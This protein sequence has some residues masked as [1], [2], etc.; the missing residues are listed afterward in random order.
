MFHYLYFLNCMVIVIKSD[1]FQSKLIPR[2]IIFRLNYVSKRTFAEKSIAFARNQMVLFPIRFLLV[3]IF[4]RGFKNILDFPLI[5]FFFLEIFDT[6]LH[7]I[8]SFV[9]DL[10]LWLI[11]LNLQEILIFFVFLL[12]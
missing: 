11:Y 9:L 10:E 5:L 2:Y 3:H 6:L 4:I 7:L 12:N 1:K 8:K